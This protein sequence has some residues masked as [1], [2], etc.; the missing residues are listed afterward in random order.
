MI[1]GKIPP[2]AIDIEEVVLGA[3]MLEKEAYAK[4]QSMLSPLKFYKEAHA[5][6]YRAIYNLD[7]KNQPI[8]ILTVTEEL[9]NSQEIDLVGGCFYITQLVSKVASSTNIEYH[10]QII[11][12]K[13]YSRELIRISS[14]INQDAYNID[15]SEVVEYL[16]KEL[17]AIALNS[18]KKLNDFQSGLID[19][20]SRA[21]YR[22]QKFINKEFLGVPSGLVKLDRITG[23]LQGGDLILLAAR[24][25]MGKTAIALFIAKNATLIGKKNVLM[26][27]LEMSEK[28]LIDRLILSETGI[29]SDKFNA[30][31]LK[32][33]DFSQLNNS[34]E[35]L[36]DGKIFI[37]DRSNKVSQ[38]KSQCRKF[39]QK[40]EL[41]LIVIDYLQLLNSDE[42][43][44]NKNIEVGE[45]S[46]ALKNL[47]MELNVPILCLSQL[48][49]QVEQ[50]GDKMPIMSDLRDSGSL[51]QDADMVLFLLRPDY[52]YN[53]NLNQILVKIA[54]NR[55]GS[56]QILEYYHNKSVNNFQETEFSG[57]GLPF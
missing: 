4:V 49:R 24:P 54:K 13:W 41:H 6:I 34:F 30:G 11:A 53:E 50:R 26:F 51:E 22:N 31:D 20:I 17:T 46:K 33:E 12:Q 36:Q 45:N 48:S 27:S 42:K 39:T 8:D 47:A 38:I 2:Q 43:H 32:Q 1:E 56:L 57:D 23:G 28:K 15:P 40:N 5:I 44:Q 19:S 16:E 55:Q 3:L 52:Y 21:E 25:S 37:D 9:R 10:A 35:I 7:K 14:K 29:D 18:T